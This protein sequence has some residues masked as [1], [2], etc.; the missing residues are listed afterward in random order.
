M[1]LK[2][3]LAS[4]ARILGATAALVLIVLW[5]SGAFAGKVEPGTVPPPSRVAP[6][7]VATGVVAEE[8]VPV[9]EEAAGTVQA[10]RRTSVSSR[11]LAVIA[12]IR[13]RAGDAVKEGDLLI[14]LDDRE[15]RAQVEQAKRA[16]DATD[17]TFAGTSND[18]ERARQ[19]LRD[20]VISRSEFDRAESAFRVAEAEQARA[21]Q[22]L[23]GA[24]VAL[25]YASLKA[26]VSGRVI[27][28]LADPGD[29]AVPGRPLLSL[30]DPEALRIEVPVRESLVSSLQ[31]GDPIEVR[32]GTAK[33]PI[34]GAVDEIVPQAEAGSRTFLVK[35]G[36][37]K[38]DAI[39]TGMFGRAILPSGT[40]RRVVVPAAAVE[41]VG[42]LTFAD[43]V[44]DERRLARRLVTLG[45]PTPSG[46][47]E[48]LSGL[49]P[50]ETVLVAESGR[51]AAG[52]K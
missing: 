26:S 22:A 30:Y 5:M 35:I 40:R 45:Q 28:R 49:R 25:S 6:A 19:L 8:E 18:F 44:D 27:D 2:S 10:A 24:E 51:P 43:V 41:R 13:V 52:K 48:V 21:R 34:A 3:V 42:Q 33:E 1:N 47:L 38:Q 39:Y 29:T 7:G 20:G 14:E 32:M 23:Q 37:P 15:L 11:I 16:V 50:G 46:D 17:A 36:L 31:L 9:I 4:A 12:D